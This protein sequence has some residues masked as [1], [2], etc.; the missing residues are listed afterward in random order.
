MLAVKEMSACFDNARD[1]SSIGVV[2]L[3]GEIY[4]PAP[5]DPIQEGVNRLLTPLL[6]AIQRAA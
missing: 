1:D 5:E 6:T 2:I 4:K 3:T